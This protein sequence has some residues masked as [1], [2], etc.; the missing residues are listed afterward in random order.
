MMTKIVVMLKIQTIL[1]FYS[2]RTKLSNSQIRLSK[3]T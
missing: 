3:M 2:R 1:N